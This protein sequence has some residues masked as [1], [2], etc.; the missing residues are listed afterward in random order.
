MDRGLDERRGSDLA[1]EAWLG[2]SETPSSSKVRILRT[3]G[4]RTGRR[5]FEGQSWLGE[6]GGGTRRPRREATHGV[7]VVRSDNLLDHGR[8]DLRVP[9][10]RDRV[11]QLTVGRS[12]GSSTNGSEAAV[13][14][15]VASQGVE[16]EVD[17]RVAKED[18][19]VL[20]DAEDIVRLGK[21]ASS[22]A[23]KPFGIACQ[24][25]GRVEHLGVSLKRALDKARPPTTKLQR[26]D[27]PLLRQRAQTSPCFSRV[28]AWTA[29]LK[30][31]TSSSGWAVTMRVL[32]TGK[33]L[34]VGAGIM[35]MDDSSKGRTLMRKTRTADMVTESGEGERKNGESKERWVG[36]QK[37]RSERNA[38]DGLP[39]Q[40][41]PRHFFL[42][43][44]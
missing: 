3:M 19:V 4:A 28:R 21:L 7:D 2:C 14:V 31:M 43:C 11:L 20:R 5:G 44:P 23:S 26:G 29:V 42:S 36:G 32:P 1:M 18:D 15:R 16:S 34:G 40:P 30:N 12:D 35:R 6:G 39:P 24:G 38:S 17:E 27:G 8:D 10:G 13:S 33:G 41:V 37:R 25:K 9:L 22:L